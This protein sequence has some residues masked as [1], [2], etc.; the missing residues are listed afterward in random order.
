VAWPASPFA[1]R[2]FDPRGSSQ[3]ARPEPHTCQLGACRRAT[4]VLRQAA[5]VFS[6]EDKKE[7]EVAGPG[8]GVPGLSTRP[9]LSRTGCRNLE[10]IPGTCQASSESLVSWALDEPPPPLV[11]D[12]GLGASLAARPALTLKQLPTY[13][14]RDRELARHPSLPFD[15]AAPSGSWCRSSC[16]QFLCRIPLNRRAGKKRALVGT[17]ET[18]RDRFR[19]GETPLRRGVVSRDHRSAY[20][21]SRR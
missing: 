5:F 15:I 14:F 7:K 3:G 16:T 21:R 1:A 12:R 17:T 18:G 8:R 20:D 4:T 13:H 9:R 6:K 11:D 2:K 10:G 19:A